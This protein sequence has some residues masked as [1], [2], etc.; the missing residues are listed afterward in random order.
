MAVSQSLSLS[1][2]VPQSL[3]LSLSLYVCLCL[4]PVSVPLSDGVS[5]CL[6]LP[7]PLS[8][9]LSSFTVDWFK[10]SFTFF[11]NSVPGWVLAQAS[12]CLLRVTAFNFIPSPPPPPAQAPPPPPPTSPPNPAPILVL[13]LALL[14]PLHGWKGIMYYPKIT[15]SIVLTWLTNAD[16]SPLRTRFRRG[17]KSQEVLGLSPEDS[18]TISSGFAVDRLSVLSPASRSHGSTST[19]GMRDDL[20]LRSQR[21]NDRCLTGRCQ[22]SES[23][24]GVSGRRA[25]LLISFE[26]RLKRLWNPS[27]FRSVAMEYLSESV[28]TLK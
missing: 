28:V 2:S 10:Y 19:G 23:L 13:R 6:G 14:W 17:S 1:V 24:F 20:G 26:G 5:D 22:L 11:T 27:I 7:L 15:H 21:S 9:P 4:C 18:Q 8:L 3:R 12:F 16:L 25:P